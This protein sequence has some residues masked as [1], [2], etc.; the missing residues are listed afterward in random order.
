MEPTI[1]AFTILLQGSANDSFGSR[2]IG[3]GGGGSD[4][5]FATK[6]LPKLV[7]SSTDM[8]A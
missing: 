6:A 5:A 1:D 2:A 7:V 4:V 8:L 3:P